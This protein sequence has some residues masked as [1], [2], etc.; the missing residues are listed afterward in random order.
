M[1]RLVARPT[2]LC[3]PRSYSYRSWE[4]TVRPYA[5][6]TTEPVHPLLYV[7]CYVH[8][9]SDRFMSANISSGSNAHCWGFGNVFNQ[10]GRMSPE[11]IHYDI[12]PSARMLAYGRDFVHILRLCAFAGG[13]SKSKSHKWKACCA[14]QTRH[15]FL[16]CPALPP[17]S[18]RRTPTAQRLALPLLLPRVV[19][20]RSWCI[21]AVQT[22]LAR[23]WS[24]KRT[25]R[26][27]ALASG[28]PFPCP[29]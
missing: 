15:P 12:A 29:L 18:A 17:P 1:C 21:G 4:K 3:W 7:I 14:R 22:T 6:K 26:D 28:R 19:L 20:F 24:P 8:T 25:R 9:A 10:Q 2:H 16:T 13:A 23:R 27:G 11:I 5:R